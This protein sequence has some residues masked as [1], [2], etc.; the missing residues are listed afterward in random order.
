MTEQWR[1]IPGWAGLYEASDHGNVRSLDRLVKGHLIKG[2]VLRPGS[3]PKGYRVYVL[4]R[5]GQR[6]A[7]TGHTLVI[8]AWVGPRPEGMHVAHRNGDRADNRLA[9]L[10][11]CTPSENERDKR[12]HGTQPNLNKTHCP[13]GHGY[14]DENTWRDRNGGR[15][16]RTCKR[17]RQAEKR[18]K[19]RLERIQLD[20]AA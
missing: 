1:P 14:T 20:T 4:C 5:D 10:R 13:A 18:R 12:S 7:H 15:Y 8:A 3:N 6:T 16:C 17:E 19:Q 2:R 11:Y 9:N